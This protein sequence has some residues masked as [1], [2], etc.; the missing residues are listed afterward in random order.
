MGTLTGISL[1]L[2]FFKEKLRRR[3]GILKIKDV[4]L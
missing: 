4:V 1:R 3:I 2:S